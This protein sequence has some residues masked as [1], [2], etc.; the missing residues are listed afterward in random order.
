M[1]PVEKYGLD[2]GNSVAIR[3]AQ[4]RDAICGRHSRAGL[5]HHLFH[6]LG[7]HALVF[8]GTLGC[9]T[10]GHQH[11][12]VRER[13]QP[14][15]MREVTRERSHRETLGRGRFHARRPAFRRRDLHD[16]NELLAGLG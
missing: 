8:F 15:R 4:Q 1:Q 3:V 14:A 16:R 12:A 9:I 6:H 13:V 2:L 5:R 7:L 10:L 11:V